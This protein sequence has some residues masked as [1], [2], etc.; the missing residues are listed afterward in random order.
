MRGKSVF[1]VLLVFL[2]GTFLLLNTET[3]ISF[4]ITNVEV[5]SQLQTDEVSPRYR[6]VG[7]SFK[8]IE[9]GETIELYGQAYDSLG[10]CEAQLWTNE[11]GGI[12][13]NYSLSYRCKEI[14]LTNF[15]KSESNPLHAFAGEGSWMTSFYNDY[16]NR[17]YLLIQEERGHINIVGYSFDLEDYS[18][19]SAWTDHG[20]VFGDPTQYHCEPHSVI[21]ETQALADY[22]ESVGEGEGTRKWRLYYAG[23]TPDDGVYIAVAPEDNPTNWTKVMGR[24]TGS[25]GEV[26]GGTSDYAHYWLTL[27]P[28]AFYFNNSVW[29]AT[30]RYYPT[31][32]IRYFTYSPNG[33]N[34]WTDVLC[35]GE[36][37]NIKQTPAWGTAWEAEEGRVMSW[38]RAGKIDF[39]YCGINAHCSHN[40]TMYF[41]YTGNP[42]V[43]NI[44]GTW[45]QEIGRICP[46]V[47]KGKDDCPFIDGTAYLY[48]G[49]EGYDGRRRL[50]VATSTTLTKSGCEPVGHHDSPIDMGAANDTWIWSNFTWSNSSV[51]FG[52]AVAWRIYYSDTSG[53]VNATD[54]ETF[55][56]GDTTPPAYSSNLINNTAPGQPTLFSLNWTDDYELSG[57]IFSTNNSGTWKNA[58]WISM[59]GPHD[60]SY[61]VAVLNSTVGA[62]V[63]WKFYANDT[64]D[65][66]AT[67][68]TYSLTTYVGELIIRILS[69]A[70]N[71]SHHKFYVPLNLTASNLISY[72][73]YIL[74]GETEVDMTD[75]TTYNG[76]HTVG[77]VKL[78]HVE[79][80]YHNITVEVDGNRSDPVYFFYCLGD[81][82]G[83][84][85]VPD[86]KVGM[87]DIALVA[88]KFGCNCGDS[89]YDSAV[90]LDGNGKIESRDIGIIAREFGKIFQTA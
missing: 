44:S 65:N 19:R 15:T 89:C 13:K 57:H 55:S 61:H 81:I 86:G 35:D 58:S 28:E 26:Y 47:V 67:S 49:A 52:T 68:D 87:I 37:C 12:G 21:W 69:P 6:N 4:G 41:N 60:T 70:N 88:R 83:L 53:N 63:R 76:S 80:G 20:I 62:L 59:S 82:T 22:R 2:V 74:D 66:W 7:S 16:D 18:N 43:E 34:N 84:E 40:G 10:L 1:A 29:L 23:G 64:S 39:G 46:T 79:D 85:G 25:N 36:Y 42:V 27:D 3:I 33:I 9:P 8:S 90:D 72:A 75:S 31:P 48:Y 5:L 32:K 78:E 54:I 17:I 24:G 14:Y 38:V 51:P 77:Y 73:T 50:G 11:T 71:T 30:A 45:E 56:V